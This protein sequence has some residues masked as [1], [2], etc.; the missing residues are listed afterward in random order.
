MLLDRVSP[1]GLLD[2]MHRSFSLLD[3]MSPDARPV[4]SRTAFP[5]L[6][7]GSDDENFY[8]EAELPGLTIDSLDISLVDGRL[9]TIRGIRREDE[10][11]MQRKWIRRERGYGAF[12][13]QI[14]LPGPVQEDQ[15]EACF[16]QGVLLIKLPK[17]AAIRP[18]RI[19]VA[20]I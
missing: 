11:D 6:N 10:T 20:T 16:R 7:A 13:R 9:L 8:V 1:W 18:R 19:E 5:P 2:E 14:E 15:I 4:Y 3:E 17:A 12:Q